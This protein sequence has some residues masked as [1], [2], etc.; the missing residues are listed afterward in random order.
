MDE[1]LENRIRGVVVELFL[2][3]DRGFP[4]D[5]DTNLISAGICDS[6]S[7]VQLAARLESEIPGLRIQDQDV[8]HE[9][10]GSIGAI[11]EFVRRSGTAT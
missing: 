6:L 2:G 3:G 7:L 10:M 8:T 9:T 1:S 4:L 11:A 5:D